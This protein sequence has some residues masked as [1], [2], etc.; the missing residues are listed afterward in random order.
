MGRDLRGQPQVGDRAVARVTAWLSL[1]LDPESVSP[2]T[3]RRIRVLAGATALLTLQGVF[4]AVEFLALGLG[5]G[6]VAIGIAAALALCNLIVL[7]RTRDARLASH[8]A[9]AVLAGMVT[10]GCTLTGGASNPYF[11][12]FLVLPVAAAAT[13]DVAGVLAWVA[14]TLTITAVFWFLPVFGIEVPSRV[15]LHLQGLQ[16]LVDRVMVLLG[17]AALGVSFVAGQRRTETE[18]AHAN[19]ELERES[20]YLRLLMHAAVAANQATSLDEALRE[21]AKSVCHA[22]SW[23][24]GHV[25]VVDANGRLVSSRIVVSPDAGLGPLL[26]LSTQMSFAP[27][28]GLP[29]RAFATRKPV[30]V[31]E[32]EVDTDPIRFRLARSLGLRAGFA[33]PVLS[34]G[35]VVAVVEFASREPLPDDERFEPVLTLVGAQLGRAAERA[36]L[37]ER[38]RQVQKLEAIAQ[39]AAGLAHEIN[40][41]MAYVRTN[42]NVLRTEWDALRKELELGGDK[43]RAERLAECDDL[44]AE[45][46]E[47]VDRTIGIVRDVRDFAHGANAPAE[48]VELEDVVDEAIRVASAQAG[49]GVRIERQRAGLPSIAGSAGRLRQVFVNL[50]V[51]AI[52]A[53]GTAGTVRVTTERRGRHALVRVEDD[54]PGIQPE[55]RA[56]L[57]EPFFTTKPVGQGTGLGLY[58]SYEIVHAHGGEIR[59]DS[60]P[61]SGSRFEVRLPIG[62]ETERPPA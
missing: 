13:L 42:L 7:R 47:G 59:V 43:A 15:P 24:A 53:I 25:H 2:D 19:D 45:S 21:C 52:H 9:L 27:G 46:A 29:G 4:T 31:G 48:P 5:E 11:S 8:A 35:E 51:N 54:G 39:L 37:E 40:N 50:V 32:N 1:G 58:V 28:E 36:S 17:L 56:R 55:V 12:W 62:A 57:F 60:E 41:P 6:A 3:M 61:G 22:M 10:F 34:H 16:G 20:A 38:L 33:V 23:A 49:P 30:A 14:I 44:L 26:E 18:L